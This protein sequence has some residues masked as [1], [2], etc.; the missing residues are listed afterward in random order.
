MRL[1]RFVLPGAVAAVAGALLVTLIPVSPATAEGP[2]P[3]RVVSGWIP[4]WMSS[5]AKPQGILSATANADLFTDVSPFWYS[6][7]AAPG[8][9]VRL[10]INPNF[11]GGQS[12][13]SWAMGQ[14]RSAGLVILPAIADGSGKGRMASVIADPT[15]RTA[16]VADIVNLVMS[17]GFDGIDLDYEVFAFSDGRTSWNATQPNWTAFVQELGA[18]LKAQ[19]KLLSV[20]IPPPCSTNGACGGQSGYWVY[21]MTGIAPFVDRI[22]LMAY[23]YSYHAIGPI[24]PINWVTSIVAYSASVMDPAKVQIG[25]PTYGR[26]WTRKDSSGAFRLSGTCPSNSGSTAQKA[27]FR[28]LTAM[29][30]ATDAEIPSIMAANG[31][32]NATWDEKSKESWFE[33]DKRVTWVD[34]G[35][36]TQT[37]T[38]RRVMWFVGPEAVLARTQLVGTYGIKA[39]AYWTVGGENQ[40][41]WPLIRAYAQSLAP[42]EATITVTGE[43]G[44]VFGQPYVVSA[45]A[46]FNGSPVIDAEATLQFRAPTKKAKWEPVQVVRTGQ[47]GSAVF[48]VTATRTG[49]YR[50]VTAAAGSIA[51]TASSPVL[52][53]VFSSVTAR[54]K[55]PSVSRGGTAKILVVARPAI[56]GQQVRI[57]MQRKTGWKSVTTARMNAKGRV[58]VS[59]PVPKKPG[60]WQFRAVVQ[61]TGDVQ[62]GTFEPIPIRVKKK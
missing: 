19:G 41:Q 42:A 14:L 22:R 44:A 57:E 23:D 33:Y 60:L 56:T 1:P 61:P 3:A 52:V 11:S 47:D 49:N 36:S 39:A 9:N 55:T 48:T 45:I 31:V 50:V 6:A 20:T 25:V 8:G 58:V 24:A 26:A 34:A 10:A 35:G 37:C 43:P 12:S 13:V 21:N 46:T 40:T 51:A 53:E 15:K 5:P 62:G 2:A 16:H 4:Y 27:A 17:Q 54:A 29:S 28:S 38:A 59:V 18:A 7:L 30:T 32:A